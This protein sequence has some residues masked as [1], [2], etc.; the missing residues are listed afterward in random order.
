MGRGVRI[1][2]I[3]IYIYIYIDASE[4]GDNSSEWRSEGLQREFTRKG[5]SK[6]VNGGGASEYR[7]GRRIGSMKL[8]VFDELCQ[9]LQFE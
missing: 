9:L 3:Y 1:I 6:S 8:V 2:Y 4:R 5:R 7:Q